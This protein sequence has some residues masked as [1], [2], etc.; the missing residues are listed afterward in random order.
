M[1]RGMVLL[2]VFIFVF[3]LMPGAALAAEGN[4]RGKPEVTGQ[5]R[6][7]EAKAEAEER[8]EAKAVPKAPPQA[9]EK[10]EK[11]P[12]PVIQPPEPEVSIPTP[13]KPDRGSTNP[14]PILGDPVEY[15]KECEPDDP[16][17]VNI[18]PD[19]L[20]TT[21]DCAA[22]WHF[23]LVGLGK[24]AEPGV[25]T[26]TFE[27]AGTIVVEPSKVLLQMQHFDITLSSGDKL[28]EAYAQVEL[29]EFSDKVRLNLSDV[30]CVTPLTPPPPSDEPTPTP[31]PSDEPTPTVPPAEPKE[32]SPKPEPVVYEVI[33]KPA[34]EP[35]LPFT[36][37]NYGL[38]LGLSAIFGSAGL[39][40]RRL[41]GAF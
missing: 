39:G 7:A 5:D 21:I 1:K 4:R 23:V 2:L 40:L 31:P 8:S 38:L 14:E 32:P 17:W 41:G 20:G 28:L 30:T 34:E 12:K 35:Y 9:K 6:A 29:S 19:H 13:V 36:G 10:K 26:A 11:A 25:L 16:I 33:V 27:K 3:S 15:P 18:N 22:N 37:G 24:G